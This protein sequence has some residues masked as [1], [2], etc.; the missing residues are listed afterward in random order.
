MFC[1]NCAKF[2]DSGQ[3]YCRK[4]GI[5][6]ERLIKLY[7]EELSRIAAD[8][9]GFSERFFRRLGTGTLSAFGA[10]GFGFIFALA[11]D[12]KF[13]IFGAEMMAWFGVFGFLLLGALS[14]LFFGLSSY[15]SSRRLSAAADSGGEELSGQGDAELAQG[16]P[17]PASAAESR[18]TRKLVDAKRS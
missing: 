17:D 1:P 10:V 11:V 14:I 3:K 5:G 9:P 7:D 13:R 18:T 6:L 15:A 4:C 12:Y 16:S 2:N 8:G